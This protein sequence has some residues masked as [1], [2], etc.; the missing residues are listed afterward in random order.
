MSDE[1]MVSHSSELNYLNQTSA[2][3]FFKYLSRQKMNSIC[4]VKYTPIEQLLQTFPT[5][6]V[7]SLKY[8]VWLQLNQ[9]IQ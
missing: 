3:H 5:I 1:V 2:N 8:W 7:K 6:N 9:V 4:N